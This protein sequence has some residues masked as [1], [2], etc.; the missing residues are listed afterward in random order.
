[1]ERTDSGDSRT[2]FHYLVSDLAN[3]NWELVYLLR[4]DNLGAWAPLLAEIDGPLSA[5]T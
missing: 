2:E 1:V 3:L 5:A 4:R